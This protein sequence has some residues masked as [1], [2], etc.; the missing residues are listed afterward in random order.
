MTRSFVGLKPKHVGTVMDALVALIQKD[1]FP[2]VELVLSENK[3]KHDIHDFINALG[4]NQHLQRLDI[5]GNL[6]GDIGARLLAKALQINSKLR[7]ILLDRNNVTLQGFSDIVYALESN[8]AM[9]NIPFPIFDVAPCMKQHPDRT[10]AVMRKMQEYLQRN[11]LG[12][13]RTNAQGFRL[14]HGLLLSST[15]QLV[16]KLVAE[17][18]E[19]MS[20]APTVGDCAAGAQPSESASAVQRLIDDAENSKQLL[21]KLQECVRC[22]QHPIEL[23]LQRVMVDLSEAIRAHLTE[24]MEGM[25]RAGVEQCPKTLG[26]QNVVNDLRKKCTDRL[27]ISDEFLRTCLIHNSGGEIMNKLR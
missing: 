4:S 18:Q 5:S 27:Q 2:L 16:D 22:D 24:T 17:T 10:D 12:L 1:D 21:P 13:K 14:Q 11:A 25:L 7:T 3:L 9:R 6:I 19:T 23:K 26:L 8:H 20:L 15:H